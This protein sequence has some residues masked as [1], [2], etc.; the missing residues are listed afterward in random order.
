MTHLIAP[1]E[2]PN[3]VPGEITLRTDHLDWQQVS[4]R[5]YRYQG[6]DVQIPAMRDFMLVAYRTGITPMKRRFD[7]RWS[8]ATCAPGAVSLLTRSQESHWNWTETVDVSHVYL[9]PTL[10]SDVAKELTGRS[11]EDVCLDDVLRTDD[12]LLFASMDALALEASDSGM[13][14]GLYAESVARQLIIHLIRHYAAITLKPE[15]K[16]GALSATQLNRVTEF[17]D[18]HL[19]TSL[20]LDT[21]ATS[22]DLATC[23][24][25]RRFKLSVGSPPY[26]Y[27][28]ECRLKRARN[29]LKESGRT[30]TD[31]AAACGFS[32]QA[33]L[34]RMFSRRYGATPSVFRRDA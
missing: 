28:L 20:T 12:P 23:N 4:M 9:S 14:S 2:L 8:K 11:V 21:L 26:A 15:H 3:W 27:V 19:D 22:L 10:V 34:T 25:A 13:G 29:L 1:E 33:H 32:D 30:I 5:S 18:A 31:I 16:T 6:Q 24:F 7:G 17:I